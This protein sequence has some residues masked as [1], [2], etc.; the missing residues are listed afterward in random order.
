MFS[1]TQTL[2]PRTKRWAEAKVLADCVAVRVSCHESKVV[3]W[4]LLI[5]RSA[6]CCCTKAR[7]LGSPRRFSCTSSASATCLEGG[8]SGKRLL[9]TGRGSHDSIVSLRNS[10][11]RLNPRVSSS[12]R[13][14][15][16]HSPIAG[17]SSGPPTPEHWTT[18]TS[19]VNPI[20][21]LQ[22]PAFYFYTAAV[23][24]I[25]RQKRFEEALEAEQDALGS[26][27][28][29]TSGYVSTAPGFANEKK[30]DHAGLVVEV[31]HISS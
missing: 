28:G 11:K 27:A 24:S 21:V 31:R 9:N 20:H 14:H 10:S 23:C 5:D 7:R 22:Q 12:L 16:R 19:A 18:P 15:F 6:G 8:A 3:E 13:S 17:P 25:Q 4:T 29:A 1:S 30:V 26:E 2:P